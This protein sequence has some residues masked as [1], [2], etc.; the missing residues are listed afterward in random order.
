MSEAK[1]GKLPQSSEK[2]FRRA[3]PIIKFM[4]KAQAWV[5]QV[6]GGRLGGKFLHGA[7]VGLLTT[8]GRKSGQKRTTPLIYIPDGENV[9]AI[10][11]QGG[12]PRHPVW[13]L[14][15]QANPEAE[16][17]VGGE[18]RKVRAREVE[19]DEK[20]ACWRLAQDIYPDFDDYQR[21]T[22]RTI[23]LLVLEPR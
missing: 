6:S 16:Y 17:Q 19:G 8:V 3:K 1:E 22:D 23:P 7:P 9:I 4:S 13:Y 2:E 14:N 10:A 15:L 11:S 12:M 20:E 21:R 5:Y 18:L